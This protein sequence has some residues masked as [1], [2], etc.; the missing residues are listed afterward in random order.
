M[1]IWRFFSGHTGRAAGDAAESTALLEFITISRNISDYIY[2][3]E[4]FKV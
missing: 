3:S 1:H 2:L 4:Y